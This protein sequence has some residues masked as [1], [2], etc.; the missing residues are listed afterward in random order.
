MEAFRE[1]FHTTRVPPCW[2]IAPPWEADDVHPASGE[3]LLIV[4]PGMAF[5][6]GL[7]ETTRLCLE[8]IAEQAGT[9]TRVLDVGA[10]SGVLS[11]ASV[12]LGTERVEA[13]EINAM[14]AENLRYNLELNHVQDRVRVHHQS[15][16]EAEVTPAPVVICNMERQHFGPVLP[17]LCAALAPDGLLFASG[18]FKQGRVEVESLFEQARLRIV[19]PRR[20]GDWLGYVLQH[21]EF[22]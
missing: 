1:F 20:K 19:S 10:G 3:H 9:L 13:F 22:G 6:T 4:H 21:A 17:A 5:G 8:F 2:W 7:H 16:S 18:F 15:F 12:R 14:A 11:V